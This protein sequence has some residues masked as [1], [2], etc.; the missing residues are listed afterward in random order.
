VPADRGRNA[1]ADPHRR[2]PLNGAA[3]TVAE[4]LEHRGTNLAE[5]LVNVEAHIGLAPTDT[6]LAAG[7]LV[8]GLGNSKSDLD[9]LLITPRRHGYDECHEVAVIVGACLSHVQ[10]LLTSEVQALVDRLRQWADQPWDVTHAPCFTP[11]ERLLLHRV[12]H[13]AVWFQGE[14]ES[15]SRL[16]P[17]IEMLARLKLHVARHMAKAIQV[18]MAGNRDAGDYVSLALAAHDLLGHSADALAAAYHFTNPTAKWRSRILKL[19]PGDWPQ[20][21]G[22]RSED[23]DATGL[24]WSLN[25]LPERADPESALSYALRIVAFARA[26]FVAAERRLVNHL[27]APTRPAWGDADAGGLATPLPYLDID[28]DACEYDNGAALGRLNEFATPL[29][30]SRTEFELALSFDGVTTPREA[31]QRVFGTQA[32][33][34]GASAVEALRQ[35]I[36]RAGLTACLPRT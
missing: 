7:S 13:S 24:F 27:P 3:M 12:L 23:G 25:R 8:E 22:V 31:A 16:L 6:L 26:V 9:L 29:E 17:P 21:V 33:D 10:I 14:S 1:S 30:V 5:I 20:V 19:L 11:A 36:Q 32:S 15:F 2:G 34:A 35:R 18:D 4:F 28:V